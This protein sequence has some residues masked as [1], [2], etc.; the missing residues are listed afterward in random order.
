MKYSYIFKKDHNNKFFLGLS[1]KD[2]KEISLSENEVY[3][4]ASFFLNLWGNKVKL[5]EDYF[6]LNFN[7]IIFVNL[8]KFNDIYSL[9]SNILIKEEYSKLY[10]IN[11]INKII[12]LL[13]MTNISQFV[14][15]NK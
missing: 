7:W 4:L 12:Q 6:E 5:N 1:L 2:K 14:K 9:W 8:R 15:V 10:T 13:E 11:E 3:S